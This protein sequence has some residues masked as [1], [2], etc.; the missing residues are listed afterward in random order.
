MRTV[1]RERGQAAVEY[2]VGCL[3]ALALALVPIGGSQSALDF[4]LSAVR[5]GFRQFL[6]ALSVP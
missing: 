4:F 5:T 6:L 1:T 2:L 3:I